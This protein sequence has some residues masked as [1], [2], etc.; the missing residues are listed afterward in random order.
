[1]HTCQSDKFNVHQN[2]VMATVGV[3]AARNCLPMTNAAGALCTCKS[4]HFTM[5]AI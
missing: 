3:M 1:M 4:K 5:G 2:F